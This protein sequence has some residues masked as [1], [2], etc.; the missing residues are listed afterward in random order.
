M[1]A[2]QQQNAG[3]LT[4]AVLGVRVQRPVR[5]RGEDCPV[6]WAVRIEE[7][8][9]ATEQ[10]DVSWVNKAE[11]NPAR[12]QPPRPMADYI[13]AAS[14]AD[15]LEPAARRAI[16]ARLLSDAGAY[17]AAARRVDAEMPPRPEGETTE[18]QQAATADGD[19][20]ALLNASIETFGEVTTAQ[21]E[22][23]TEYRARVNDVLRDVYG[24]HNPDL[25][26]AAHVYVTAA[27]QDYYGG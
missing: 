18:A 23:D 13:D 16:P 21:M 24:Y 7:S 8:C 11:G 9:C 20:M 26:R 1:I 14:Y 4:G 2:E 25:L 15:Y 19:A 5:P 6:D 22:W 3:P 10:E 17:A 27:E 12:L